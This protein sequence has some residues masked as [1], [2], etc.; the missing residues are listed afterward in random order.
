V[1]GCAIHVKTGVWGGGVGCGAVGEWMGGG[2]KCNMEY[3]K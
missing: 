2:G 3:E 1:G